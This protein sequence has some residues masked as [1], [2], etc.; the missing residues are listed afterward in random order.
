MQAE[1]NRSIA[2]R[3]AFVACAAVAVVAPPG[4][5][6]QQAPAAAATAASEAPMADG[7]IRKVDKPAGKLTIRHGEIKNL[8]MPPMTMVFKAGDPAMLDRVKRGD[9]VRFRA[10]DDNGQLVVTEMQPAP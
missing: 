6:A 3:L 1:P 9:K 2:A 5:I 7:E 4:A 8:E 10:R